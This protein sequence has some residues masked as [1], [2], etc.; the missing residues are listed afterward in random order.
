MPGPYSP[1][2]EAAGRRALRARAL[3]FL[4][5]LDP[6][7]ADARAQFAAAG[8]MTERMAALALLVARG[9]GEEALASSTPPGGT[10][11]W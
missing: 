7:A 5:A 2:A 8:D 4:T 10:T 9:Q 1:D 6:G 11:G 3:A